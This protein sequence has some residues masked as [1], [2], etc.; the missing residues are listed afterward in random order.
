MSNK[1]PSILK[2]V[3]LNPE[4]LKT[5]FPVA[6]DDEITVYVL[7]ML[8]PEAKRRRAIIR[9][10][11]QAIKNPTPHDE[12][13]ANIR[14]TAA[15][16]ANWTPAFDY[17]DEDGNIEQLAYSPDNALRLLRDER[18]AGLITIIDTHAAKVEN[19]RLQLKEDA[20]KN[21]GNTSAG[22]STKRRAR[23]STQPG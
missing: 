11:Y 5:G 23:G 6:L 20:K 9:D 18:M 8:S 21:S 15:L 13:D 4:Y 16:V 2:S 19:Y 1:R 14:G 7:S 22:S 12:T 3:G 17:P 10:E